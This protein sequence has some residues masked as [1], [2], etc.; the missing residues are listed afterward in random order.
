MIG[1]TEESFNLGRPFHELGIDGG[2]VGALLCTNNPTQTCTT[3]AECGVG[4]FC[5]VQRM[6]NGTAPVPPQIVAVTDNGITADAVHF[7]QSATLVGDLLHPFPSPTHRKIHAVQNAGDG[8]TSCDG[9]LSGA[10]THGNVVAGIIA[11]APGDLGFSYSKAIDPADG[12]PLQNL[13]LDALARGARIIMQ[14]AAT[15][16]QCIYAELVEVGGNVNPGSLSDRLNY[17]I[18]PRTGGVGACSGIPGGGEEVHLQV[19]PFGVPAF[20]NL[21]QNPA[22]GMYTLEAQQI[23]TFLVNNRDYMVFSPVGSQGTDPGDPTINTIWPD[24]FDGTDADDCAVPCPGTDVKR[25]QQIP[26]PATAKN[27]IT[28]GGTF[29]DIW[30]ESGTL[31][32]EENDYNITSHGPAT[33]ASLRTAPLLMTVGVDGSGLF[34]YPLFQAAATNRSHDNDNL[35]PVENEIDDQNYGTS[36]ASGFMTA[37]GAIVRDYFAQGFYP[38][39]TRQSADRMPRVSG[40]LVRAALVASANFLDQMTVPSSQETTTNDKLVGNTRGANIGSVSG[41]PVGVMGNNA[42]GYGRPV[43]DQVLPITNYPPT[44]GIGAPDTLEY[45]AAGLIIYDMMGTGEPVINNT[46]PINCATGAGCVEKTFVVDAV[47]TVMAGPTRFVQNGQ[48]RI[49]LSWPDAPSTTLGTPGNLGSGALVNDIDLEVEGPGPDNNIATTA[50][51]VVY[52]GNIYILGQPLIIGQWSLG[53]S[54]GPATA[55][56]THNNIEAVHLSSFVNRFAPNQGNQLTTGTW[57]VRVRRGTGGATAGQ[58][59]AISGPNEDADGNGR[60]AT[61]SCNN[62]NHFCVNNAQCGAGNTCVG[63]LEDTDGDGLLD[64]GGQPYALV[65]SGPVLGTAGQT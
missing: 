25:P 22:N 19:M 43:L 7:S 18:C 8:G 50:D 32:Q 10:N 61:G 21:L 24:F 39:A 64:A 44:R 38:T 46:S 12:V 6:N 62:D 1:N 42:Q 49:A 23:D 55:H 9:I 45:P 59:T 3:D 47:N 40:S 31:N 56:D 33:A 26:P 53:R 4:N 35:S 17:A 30:T 27:S 57:K 65:I 20:D 13:S 37:A 54:A 52:D 2:G 16:N 51:N 41:V 60:L 11:G 29:S 5:R 14:D 28:V 15:P 63:T 34:G 58:I 48:L 36:F